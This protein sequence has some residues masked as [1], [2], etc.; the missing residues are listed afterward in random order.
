MIF[1]IFFFN[2]VTIKNIILTFHQNKKS[3][4]APG[5]LSQKEPE[6]FIP[7]HP[8]AAHD[9]DDEDFQPTEIVNEVEEADA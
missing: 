5:T 3:W 7:A 9:S 8:G 2:N 4:S 6:H 1:V